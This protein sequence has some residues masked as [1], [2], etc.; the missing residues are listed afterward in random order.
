MPPRSQRGPAPDSFWGGRPRFAP[1]RETRSLGG[2][3]TDGPTKSGVAAPRGHLPPMPR[4]LASLCEPWILAVCCFACS[5]QAQSPALTGQLQ[6]LDGASLHGALL[7]IDPHRGVRW[8]HPAAAQP[9]EFNPRNLQQVRF[10]RSPL[11]PTNSAASCRFVF[12]NGD[13]LLGRL[14]SL[15]SERV[16]LETWFAGRVSAPRDSLR[17]MAFITGPHGSYYEGPTGTDGWKISSQGPQFIIRAGPEGAKQVPAAPAAPWRY[18]DGAFISEGVGFLGRDFKL[19]DQAR[20]EFDLAWQGPLGLLVNVYTDVLD[21]FDY[22][23]GAYQ[24]NLGSGYANLMRIQGNAGMMHLGMAQI[25]AMTLKNKARIELRMSRQQ[26]S[27]TLL[28]DG[29]QIQ[30]WRDP[31]GFAGQGTGITFYSQRIGPG[32]RISSLRVS[33]WDG[34]SDAQGEPHTNHSANLVKLANSDR[35]TGRMQSV[36]DDKLVIATAQAEL[37]IPLARVTEIILAGDNALRPPR[38]PGSVQLHL[39]TGERVTLAAATWNGSLAGGVS[40]NFGPVSLGA[41]WV[42][43]LEFNPARPGNSADEL[44][45]FGTEVQR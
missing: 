35:V 38:Q 3:F 45:F 15:D 44:D 23:Q 42:R 9:I 12:L 8:Q 11:L 26:N 1:R 43:S 31:A 7:G 14:V 27:I 2:D 4:G 32:V 34:K 16:V 10:D 18:A 13:E 21:R 30:H 28:S 17:S 37:T 6:F 25:P 29:E 39:P 41:A 5:L 33:A 24:I 22:S 19:P 20:I 36:R 40:P